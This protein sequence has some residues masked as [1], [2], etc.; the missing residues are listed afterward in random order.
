[1]RW[2]KPHS[3]PLH[4]KFA[5]YSKAFAIAGITYSLLIVSVH[6]KCAWMVFG[7]LI[8]FC[9]RHTHPRCVDC[10]DKAERIWL[11]MGLISG[12]RRMGTK[13]RLNRFLVAILT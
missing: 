1:M 3:L 4:R 11:G 8:L 13:S 5:P 10:L 7:H 6:I 9:L 2:R 12:I